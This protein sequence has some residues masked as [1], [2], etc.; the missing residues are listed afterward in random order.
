MRKLQTRFSSFRHWIFC[1]GRI[2]IKFK[3]TCWTRIH[4]NSIYHFVAYWVEWKN[5]KQHKRN[6]ISTTLTTTTKTLN[7][8]IYIFFFFFFFLNGVNCCLQH[9][10][11]RKKKHCGIICMNEYNWQ[12][13]VFALS[14]VFIFS[15]RFSYKLV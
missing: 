8:Y 7:I 2:L 10:G 12:F 3:W 5:S 9:F 1:L 13:V 15:Y 11:V 14:V 4:F 6:T